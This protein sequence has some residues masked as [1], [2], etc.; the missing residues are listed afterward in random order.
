MQDE[1]AE[2]V[3]TDRFLGHEIVNGYIGFPWFSE[4]QRGLATI[5]SQSDESSSIHIHGSDPDASTVSKQRPYLLHNL[6]NGRRKVEDESS[7]E[8]CRRFR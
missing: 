4:I 7:Q 2:P 3:L 6:P 8:D 5:P 1:T